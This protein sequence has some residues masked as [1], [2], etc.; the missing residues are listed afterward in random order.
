MV[1]E[2]CATIAQGGGFEKADGGR[3]GR[4]A[5]FC[6]WWAEMNSILR[7]RRNDEFFCAVAKSAPIGPFAG[8]WAFGP[9]NPCCV[10]PSLLRYAAD[11]ES[12][13]WKPGQRR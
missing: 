9:Q 4:V 2:W 7:P 1:L 12:D 6:S 3:S 11:D 13:S 10:A 5:D 8:S